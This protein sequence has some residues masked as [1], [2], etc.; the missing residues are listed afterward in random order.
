MSSAS[1]TVSKADVPPWPPHSHPRSCTTCRHRKVKCDRKQPCAICVRAG[2]QCVYPPGP[3]RAPKRLWTALDA[4]LLDRLS[5]LETMIRHLERQEGQRM[6]G[7]TATSSELNQQLQMPDDHDQDSESLSSLSTNTR[8][9]RHPGRLLIDETR[10]CYISNSLLASMG[11]EVNWTP[12]SL[13]SRHVCSIST[14]L[15]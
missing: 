12:P 8:I 7:T 3:G 15:D 5:R 13:S 11:D 1:S 10:S 4:R 9:E 14:C 6:K 2:I